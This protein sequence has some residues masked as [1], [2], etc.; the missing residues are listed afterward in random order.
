M[1]ANGDR[2]ERA[3]PLAFEEGVRRLAE[4]SALPADR[5]RAALEAV[6]QVG[7]RTPADEVGPFFAF[8]LHQFLSSGA[9]F[10]ATL[11]PPA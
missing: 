2:L 10:Y 5:C 11:E 4:A 6:L 1:R 9:S 8:R 7:A 3:K